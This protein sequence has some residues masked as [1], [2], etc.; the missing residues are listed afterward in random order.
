MENQENR[1]PQGP[2]VSQVYL[3]IR[4]RLKSDL[5]LMWSLGEPG[6]RGGVGAPGEP[7][8]SGTLGPLGPKG[9]RGEPG[10]D[11]PI[12]PQGSKGGKGNN[13]GRLRPSKTTYSYLRLSKTIF[14]QGPLGH[15]G[16][17]DPSFS[18]PPR[19][20]EEDRNQMDLEDFLD[21]EVRTKDHYSTSV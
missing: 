7:G 10:Q 19:A 20:R 8:F 17:Q 16:L 14:L 1:A 3:W 13:P 2:K 21:H 9:L 15:R 12:G 11:G 18:S 6:P 5:I 4:V